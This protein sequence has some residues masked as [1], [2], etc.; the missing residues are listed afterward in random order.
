MTQ[1]RRLLTAIAMGTLICTAACT[2]SP[3]TLALQPDFAMN[4]SAGLA[5]VSFRQSMPG[6]TDQ[7]F[8][9]MIRNGMVHATTGGVLPAAAHTPS[10]P[11]RIVWHVAPN[12]PR[13]TSRL[14]VNIFKASVPVAY[15]Q[16]L[17]DNT[18][19]PRAITNIIEGMTRRLIAAARPP[20]AT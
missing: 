7:E 9:Q 2:G 6:T 19:S 16:A 18:A 4:T 13:G 8:E 17:I 14:D 11:L 15:E 20:V 1:P 5:N 12:G 3:A 10:P